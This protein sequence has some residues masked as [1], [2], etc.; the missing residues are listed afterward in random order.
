M[1]KWI[2][3]AFLYLAIVIVGYFAYEAVFGVDEK[4]DAHT[5]EHTASTSGEKEAGKAHDSHSGD[6]LHEHGQ[7]TSTESEVK[8]TVKEENQSLTVRLEDL[9]GNPVTDL[10]VSHEKLLHLIVVD[11]HLDQYFHLHPEETTPGQFKVESPLKE[12]TYKAFV[13]IKPKDLNYEVQAI[14]FTV[15]NPDTGEHSHSSLKIDQTLEK[16]VNGNKVTMTPTSLVVNE[17]V[18]LTFDVHGA[19][20]ESYLG[21]LGHVVILDE[22]ANEYLHVH[23]LD[24]DT[25]V[26]ETQFSKP[27]I[28]K[29]WAEFQENGNVTVY[30]FIVE[31]KS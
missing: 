28:Y 10:E 23:P 3:S 4:L 13:D 31:V 8:V 15:G 2:I 24:G 14:L 30:P 16:T 6:E 20:L 27:G 18:T 1:K 5:E 17:P 26:F 12:G 22:Q 29:I 25:P 19:K 7:Q 9:A 21:A 11:D